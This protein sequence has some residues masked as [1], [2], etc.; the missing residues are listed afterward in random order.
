MGDFYYQDNVRFCRI[1]R[2]SL[3]ESLEH[4]IT[5]YDMKYINAEKLNCLKLDYETCM[6]LL[7]G[8]IR[9]LLNN[10]NKEFE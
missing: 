4:L 3:E 5:A 1:S 6:R 2:G 8:Y 7:N 9:Y 10:K